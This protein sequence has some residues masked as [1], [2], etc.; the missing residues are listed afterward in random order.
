MLLYDS[1][2][3]LIAQ[4]MSRNIQSNDEKSHSSKTP[5]KHKSC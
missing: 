2:F 3:F 4:N 5:I 1:D